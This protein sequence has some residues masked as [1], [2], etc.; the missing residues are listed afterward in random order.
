M[1]HGFSASAIRVLLKERFESVPCSLLLSVASSLV[2][3]Q[4]TTERRLFGNA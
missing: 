2:H 4:D 1:A 3:K